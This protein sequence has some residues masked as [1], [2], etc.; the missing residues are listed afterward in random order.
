M[1]LW[2]FCHESR[3]TTQIATNCRYKAEGRMRALR[4]VTSLSL[5]ASL[6][7]CASSGVYTPYPF[8]TPGGRTAGGAAPKTAPPDPAAPVPAPVAPPAN[9]QRP[10]PPMTAATT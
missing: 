7:A 2:V 6:A 3:G 9:P 1:D 5:A 8:P 4:L 10:L